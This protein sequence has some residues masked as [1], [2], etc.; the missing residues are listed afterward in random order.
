MNNDEYIAGKK[1]LERKLKNTIKDR[2]TDKTNGSRTE[3][4]PGA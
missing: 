1:Q 4:R 2:E 3:Q